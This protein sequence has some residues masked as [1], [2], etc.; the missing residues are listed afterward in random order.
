MIRPPRK[1]GSVAALRTASQPRRSRLA[2]RALPALGVISVAGVATFTLASTPRVRGL[3]AAAAVVALIA[4]AI[5]WLTAK[6]GS[7]SSSDRDP[8]GFD[9][10]TPPT[11]L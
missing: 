6:S 1:A 3:G 8:K 11:A 10:L 7:L 4:A 5:V 9:K 2:R